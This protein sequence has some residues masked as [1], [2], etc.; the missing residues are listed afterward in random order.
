M[1]P[2]FEGRV[3]GWSRGPAPSAWKPGPFGALEIDLGGRGDGAEPLV[4]TGTVGL[5]DTLA[6]E[7]LSGGNARL[8]YDHWGHSAVFS[9][10][11]E[12]S[13]D[14]VHTVR[15]AFPSFS[16]LD[17][18]SPPDSGTGRLAVDLDGRPVWEANV[19]FNVAG[20]DT[21]VIGRNAAGSSMAAL[22]LS[23]VMAD[24]RQLDQGAPALQK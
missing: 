16:R 23:G 8:V 7:W 17:S 2:Y 22:R 5:A 14:R 1:I 4:A 13:A 24:V 20:S 3:R 12:W 18:R 10:P 21:L 6:V 15:I 11:F 9:P 19:P